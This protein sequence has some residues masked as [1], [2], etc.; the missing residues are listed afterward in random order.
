MVLKG[1]IGKSL[2]LL[3][4]I[5][6]ETIIEKC[7]VLLDCFGY[8]LSSNTVIRNN[9]ENLDSIS[10][11]SMKTDF[12]KTD[13]DCLSS[14]GSQ[15]KH[16]KH[17]KSEVCNIME[18]NVKINTISS[19]VARHHTKE[20]GVRTVAR[21]LEALPLIARSAIEWKKVFSVILMKL[22]SINLPNEQ[23][24][25]DKNINHLCSSDKMED[26]EDE[27]NHKHRPNPLLFSAAPGST[28]PQ[29]EDLGFSIPGLAMG[30]H[31]A[32]HGSYLTVNE[33]YTVRLKGDIFGR[34]ITEV[35]M[36]YTNGD[37]E[38]FETN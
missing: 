18:N 17:S 28:I 26:V 7:Q 3:D 13:F 37:L 27:S 19:S 31:A 15:Q 4:D 23:Y 33:P 21:T 14:T 20:E 38:P 35:R 12:S 5:L 10:T 6:I 24:Q 16:K 9:V 8:E 25:K 22:E 1:V 2:R 36:S 32:V 29:P 30:D 11:T 34:G